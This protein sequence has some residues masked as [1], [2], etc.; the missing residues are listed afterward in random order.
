MFC[1]HV[2]PIRTDSSRQ[3]SSHIE[4]CL[5]YAIDCE[6]QKSKCKSPDWPVVMAAACGRT[7]GLC[8]AGWCRD[9]IQGCSS[10]RTQC[11]DYTHRAYM[12]QNC[13]R[14]CEMCDPSRSGGGAQ[15]PGEHLHINVD[16]VQGRDGRPSGRQLLLRFRFPAP[17]RFR[18]QNDRYSTTST[19]RFQNDRY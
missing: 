5:A 3:T 8:S 13:A 2:L 1:I 19:S 7:C 14:T 10:L 12:T 15:P 18:L 11:R 17:F 6:Q 16:C 9:N 4:R